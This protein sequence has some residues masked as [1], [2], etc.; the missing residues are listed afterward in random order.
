[1]TLLLEEEERTPCVCVCLSV[2]YINSGGR[3]CHKRGW[4]KQR[5]S[6]LIAE[7]RLVCFF[8][9]L[10]FPKKCQQGTKKTATTTA[11]CIMSR[12]KCLSDWRCSALSAYFSRKQPFL[13][14]KFY[15]N[16]LRDDDSLQRHGTKGGEIN[17]KGM[18]NCLDDQ[19]CQ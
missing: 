3:V 12:G 18:F 10:F 13:L 7:L 5:P 6:Q 14:L 15:S 1:M 11:V 19:L 9:Y 2:S 17:N 4:K 16:K 8:S